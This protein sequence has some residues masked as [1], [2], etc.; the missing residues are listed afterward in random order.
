MSTG[1]R[2]R[3]PQIVREN[4]EKLARIPQADADQFA[5]D[6]RN[7]EAALHLLQA[8]IQAL[9]DMGSTC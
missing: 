1:D 2:L 7:V 5:G 8:S 9:I 6:F 4:L 3:K